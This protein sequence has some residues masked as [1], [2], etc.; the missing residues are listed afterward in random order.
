MV[1]ERSPVIITVSSRTEEL[2]RLEDIAEW[3]DRRYL[4][5]LLGFLFPGVGNT[6]S[7]LL[8]LY[9]VYVAGKLRAHPV[10]IAR[11][12]INLAIDAIIGS[13]PLFGTIFD[14]F[15][16]AHVRNLE[17]LKRRAEHFD[18]RFSDW[19]IITLACLLF[20]AAILLPL[21]LLGFLIVWAFRQ[22]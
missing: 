8:G 16:R 2:Q 14:F 20:L 11:M 17:L 18:A 22:F 1:Q 21:V 3:M 4:D 10:L 6:L 12:L 19:L 7:A 5:P 9:G 13:I 15:F